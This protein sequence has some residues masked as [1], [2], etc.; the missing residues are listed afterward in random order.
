MDPASALRDEVL[1]THDSFQST[2]GIV[3]DITEAD[4]LAFDSIGYD[5]VGPTPGA[6]RGLRCTN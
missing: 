2:Q 1:R 6:W 5:V 4:R 3:L